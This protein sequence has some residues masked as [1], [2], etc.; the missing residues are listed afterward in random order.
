MAWHFQSCMLCKRAGTDF[1]ARPARC[2]FGSIPRLAFAVL[3]GGLPVASHGA[4]LIA[5]GSSWRYHKGTVEPAAV[6]EAWRVYDFDDASWAAGQAPFGYGPEA[7]EAPSCN[8]VL[9]DMAGSYTT[10]FLRKTFTVADPAS[11]TNLRVNADFD[12]GF[13][14]WINRQKVLEVNGPDGEPLFTSI[15]SAGHEAGV[16]EGYDLADPADY[17]EP[18]DN[19]V[20]VQGFNAGADSTDFKLDVELLSFQRVAD[21]TFSEDRGFYDA[22]FAVT[23]ATE[24]AGATI[25]YTTD[26][27][28]PTA[29]TGS[30]GGTNVVVQ[31][32]ATC[33]LRAAAFKG[34]YEPTNVDTHTYVF[35]DGVLVQP[36]NP[37][38][39]PTWWANIEIPDA[40]ARGITADYEMDPQIVNDPRYS[41]RIKNDL[42]SLPSLSIV[43][44]NSHMFSADAVYQATKA[45]GSP[46]YPCS[47]EMLYPAD[48]ARNYQVDCGIKAHSWSIR[49]R[50]LRLLFKSIYGP[51]KLRRDFFADAPLNAD[52]AT[53]E[54]DLIVLRAGCNRSISMRFQ[55]TRVCY[56]RDEWVRSTFIACTGRGSHGLF[57]H[58]YINGLYWG[59]YNPVERP[60]DAFA[61]AY[62]GGDK[63]N[64]FARNH[65]GDVSGD[66]ARYLSMMSRARAGGLA[67]AATYNAMQAYID[68]THF[69]DYIAVNWFAGVGDWPGNNWYGDNLNVP[70]EPF[71]H[72]CWDAE[73]CWDKN[74]SSYDETGTGRSHGGAWIHPDFYVRNRSHDI[75]VLWRAL[76]DNA[77]FRT[78]MADRVYKHCFNDAPLTLS[79][80]VA[81]WHTL[82][83]HVESAFVGESARWGD[84][85]ESTPVDLDD[86]HNERDK[87]SNMMA[88]S[89]NVNVFV[90]AL[91]NNT[92]PLYPSLDPPGFTQHGG[93]IASGFRLT[94]SNPNSTGTI[95]YMLDG[96][97][98]RAPGGSRVSGRLQYTGP[99]TLSK[100]THVQARVYKSNGTWSAVHAATYNFTA[101]YSKIRITELLYNPDGGRDYEFIELK[102]TGTAPRGLSQMRFKGVRY[103][104]APGAELDAG[105]I[106]VLARNAAAFATRYPGTPVFG[107]YDGALDNGGERIALLDAEGRTVTAVRYDDDSPWPAE[108]DGAGFSLVLAD[109]LGEPDDPA[110]WRASNLIGG[111]PGYG[112]GQPYRVV[113]SE[114]LTHTDP[115][116]VDAIELCN[117]GNT[118][119]DIG[120]WFLSD[121][122]NAYRKFGIPAGTVLGAGGYAVF[123]EN[124]FNA[125][126]ND[127]ACFALSSHG[128]ELYLTQ[129]DA[130]S[131]LL[132]RAEARF[133]GAANGVAFARYRRTDG[134]CDFVAQAVG[135][136]LGAANAYPR[137]G[138][139]VINEV[140]YH[141]LPG[142][143]E[144]IE[145]HNMTNTAVPLYH[146]DDPANTWEIDGA[147]SYTF[148]PGLEIPAGGYLLVVDTNAAAFRALYGVAADV[149]IVGP[150]WGRLDNDGESVKLWRPDAPDE[151]GVARILV[152]RVAYNDNSPWP[153]SPDGL[154]PSLERQDP[155]SYGNDPVNW[156]ASRAAG[157]TPG[158]RNSGVLVPA[159][160]GW[161]YHDRGADLGTAWR[162]AAGSYDDSAWPDG[163]A[164][165]GYAEPGAYPD[166]DTTVSYGE[167]PADKHMTTYFRRT[168]AVAADPGNVTNLVLR[169]KYDDGFVAYLNGQELLRAAMPAGTIS[170]ATAAASHTASGYETFDLTPQAGLLAK[171]LNVLAVE[172]HQSGA[173]SSDLFMDIE[174]LHGVSELPAVATPAI[175]P[176]GGLFTNSVQVALSCAT[177]GATIFYT[178][179]G[180]DPT[181]SAT[182]YTGPFTLAD[183]APVKACAF[184]AS[185]SPS[186]IAVAQFEKY[187]E[188]VATPT[189]APAGGAFYGAVQVTLGT[190]T[191]GAT[192]FYTVNGADPTPSS[193]RYTAPFTLSDDAT[194]RARAYKQDWNA[195]AVAQA[196]FDEQTPS[197]AFAEGASAGS[198]GATPVQ[199]AVQLTGSSPYAVTVAYAATGGSATGGG[200]DYTLPA[201]TLT[202]A[203]GQTSGAIAF[204]VTDDE[205]EE[206]AETVVVTL[207]GPLNARLGTVAQHTYTIA[208]NDKL[209]VAYN[210]LCWTNTQLSAN[211]TVYTRSEGGPLVD[212]NTGNPLACTLSLDDGGGGPYLTQ[213]AGPAAGTD[214]YAVFNGKVDCAGLISYGANITLTIAGLDPS[215]R[216]EFVLFGNRDNPDYT[217]RITKAT[218]SDVVDF[219]NESSAGLAAPGDATTQI[220]NGWNRENGY[221][222][223]YTNVDPGPDGDLV[224]T[225]ADND[226]KFYA[227][228]LM[229]R[230]IRPQT[231]VGFAATAAS[232]SEGASPVDLIV[233]VNPVPIDTVTVDYGVSG[234]TATGGGTDYALAAGT[235]TFSP[236]Q[237][238]RVVQF[239]VVDDVLEEPDETIVVQLANPAN[240]V[241]GAATAT[242]TIADNDAPVLLFTAY[243]DV[244]WADGQLSQ[245]ITRYTAWTAYG[246]TT[247]GPLVDYALGTN[248]TESVA[249]ATTVQ[250]WADH[251]TN[252]GATAVSGTDAYAVFDG[253]VDTLGSAG[254]GENFTFAFAGL[255][256]TLRYTL[257]MYG[258]RNNAA[259]TDR[260]SDYVI[261]DVDS[262]DNASSAGTTISGT[263]S[264]TNDT[265]TYC[266]GY[267]TPNGF[268]ARFT[269]IAAGADGDMLL[270]VTGVAKYISAFALQ[271]YRTPGAGGTVKIARGASWRFHKGTAEASSPSAAWQQVAFDDSGWALGPAPLGYETA[272]VT[273]GTVLD[274]MRYTYSTV[275]LRRPFMLA[276]PAM[277]SELALSVRYDDGFVAWINAEEVARVNAP[278]LP[279]DPVSHQT[280]TGTEADSTHER[281]LAGGDLPALRAGTN[282][283]AALAINSSVFSADLAF[284]LELAV[285][286][287]SRLAT[288]ADADQDGMT[289]AW[290]IDRFGGTGVA[291]GGPTDDFDGDGRNNIEEFVAG[292]DP[293]DTNQLFAVDLSSANGTTV[294]SFPTIPATGTGYGGLYRRY[295]LHYC[296]DLA[297]GTWL[298]VPACTNLPATGQP[299]A[300]TN[301]APAAATCYRAR[302]WLE[303]E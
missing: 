107:E 267:N 20:A 207:S 33:C 117:L 247:A 28:A 141:P 22:P 234:G 137:V 76:D 205:T 34:G 216:Y 223:R 13:I 75:C 254:G 120:G 186:G 203:P 222:V 167:N 150:F 283:L 238:A 101:H 56:T 159:M 91:R 190:A 145:L 88:Y 135:N 297:A 272:G 192:L 10:V 17:L 260:L 195:S 154:G 84:G 181:P 144:F 265:T 227:N 109:E 211:I 298:A 77:D 83:D 245:N 263:G 146:T 86:F 119:V 158:A 210:D 18:G 299:V 97:D 253:K 94:L 32:A 80:C 96:S 82:C 290:E 108:A 21:T 230:A 208:D 201:G 127:P 276:N 136:T 274:D 193:T 9:T 46:E 175:S 112:D 66:P 27:S 288:A 90:A 78:L 63:E 147:V 202:F 11:I 255:D 44:Q 110:S 113:I 187:R 140:M 262:F 111:S 282:V 191:A 292:T 39:F 153:E 289:D 170:Y 92:V 54:F 268:V 194:V 271:A 69:C 8:T 275:Y 280:Y 215:L 143:N 161:R 15:A 204:S 237:T 231:V 157:G 273:Y 176:P 235:L 29:T 74:G 57:V 121:S 261:S 128:D 55:P 100:T 47:I 236:G 129:W 98:P 266:T 62:F 185:H 5:R 155:E 232:G 251:F 40:T 37:P 184:K 51:S 148:A 106:I 45:S 189:L 206:G 19:V 164:P 99:V 123:D 248:L 197:V 31:I 16:Y 79:N 242:Y 296:S 48:A 198:E 180:A 200:T 71:M 81:R 293:A 183:T 152:D 118:S 295:A 162:A 174:L 221:V 182:P 172:L 303:G 134:E 3:M 214:A 246:L 177:A 199:L 131:N 70:P 23:I 133:G 132:Y 105:Q 277:V 25:R 126:T 72:F 250:G 213:G 138:P 50:S 179:N 241:L 26:G 165:L 257:V 142:S 178:L 85:F 291:G 249:V 243:N 43:M 60:D 239:A 281:T 226:S 166:L 73:D 139:I 169:A 278:G 196:F 149:Q 12:D 287:H 160:A 217:A 240:A 168:F 220:C 209:F 229:L 30:A 89:N 42:K 114:A 284:D 225:L 300:Y 264:W 173:T 58:L 122:A 301:P 68:V 64:W 252:Q 24:T 115:P 52:S 258:D 130:A 36:N 228:A 103:T 256:P 93:A 259:Y 87:V 67:N 61:E 102:N 163:N 171:G 224:L 233:S 116:E 49:K 279:G 294:V 2:R 59:L 269:R 14:V 65:G 218:L 244:L 156:A 38:G 151:L 270:T 4:T 1:R 7:H 302:V 53:D 212:S 124:A 6:R 41:G 95:Y 286:E 219:V 285:V 125:D 104:F 35:L 188:T